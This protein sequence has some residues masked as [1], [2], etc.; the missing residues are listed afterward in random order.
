M[1]N[2]NGR[3]GV[4]IP[5]GQELSNKSDKSLCFI[6]EFLMKTCDLKEICLLPSKIFTHTS[7]N[8]CILYF[9]KRKLGQDVV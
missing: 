1:L 6:R 7:I 5:N 4:V 3:C 8:T 2:I 9:Y